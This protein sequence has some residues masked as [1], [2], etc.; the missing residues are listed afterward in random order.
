MIHIDKLLE[1]ERT[2]L[3][4][5]EPAVDKTFVKCFRQEHHL[6]Q[7]ALA[8]ILGV[9]KKAIE[10]WEQG[11]NPVRG[12]SAV[13]LQ[14]LENNPSLLEQVYHV[15]KGVRGR[16]ENAEYQPVA[17]EK[18]ENVKNISAFRIVQS[19]LAAII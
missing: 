12:S 14:L 2:E 18:V 16:P 10:K 3:T 5:M 19:S 6:T 4:V 17:T 7:L 13:L 1:S 15:K 9:T 8:N 11:R